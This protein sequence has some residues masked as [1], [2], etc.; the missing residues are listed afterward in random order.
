MADKLIPESRLAKAVANLDL[1]TSR[2]QA[3][4]ARAAGAIIENALEA[5]EIDTEDGRR[6]VRAKEGALARDLDD[7]KAVLAG[8]MSALEAAKGKL[9][10]EAQAEADALASRD[11][12]RFLQKA[13]TLGRA[14]LEQ[15]Y[16]L[17]SAM[18]KLALSYRRLLEQNAKFYAHF[19]SRIEPDHRNNLGFGMAPDAIANRLKLRGWLRGIALGKFMADAS[20]TPLPLSAQPLLKSPPIID[21]LELHPSDL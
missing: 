7:A 18:D 20:S 17:D 13:R 11:E 19:S 14:V 10:I 21:L 12:E 2:L 4:V 15:S 8:H 16:D 6:A 5:A 3:A 1:R 9:E